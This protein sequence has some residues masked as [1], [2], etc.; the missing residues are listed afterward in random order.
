[1]DRFL[2]LIFSILI[3]ISRVLPAFYEK[4]KKDFEKNKTLTLFSLIA[5]Y[6]L[7]LCSTYSSLLIYNEM[8]KTTVEV[9]IDHDK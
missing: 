5:L 9:I 7:I 2:N 1:M 6:G 3:Q 4:V 8:N